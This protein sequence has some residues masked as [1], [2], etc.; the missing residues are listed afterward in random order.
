M[1]LTN[2]ELT[3]IKRAFETVREEAD[4][5]GVSVLE[6]EIVGLVPQAAL[7]PAPEQTLQLAGFRR[8]QV[9][10]ERLKEA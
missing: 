4:R 7:P 6:S 9:L 10:E 3:S 5:H 1:N 2:F 8:N